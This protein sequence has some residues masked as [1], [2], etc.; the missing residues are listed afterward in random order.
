MKWSYNLV[1]IKF[2]LLSCGSLGLYTRE[3]EN[4]LVAAYGVVSHISVCSQE[5]NW[6]S[7][8]IPFLVLF[9]CCR[10]IIVLQPHMGKGSWG[11][12]RDA[13]HTS[14]HVHR[15]IFWS[16][17]RSLLVRVVACYMRI[18]QTYK[19]LI[20]LIVNVLLLMCFQSLPARFAKYYSTVTHSLSYGV[21]NGLTCQSFFGLNRFANN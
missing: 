14:R 4:T 13:L 21:V 7:L 5:W 18:G 16:C 6:L 8:F 19:W 15:I 20:L 12:N 17:F 2:S 1:R 3:G 10:L 11:E 9:V